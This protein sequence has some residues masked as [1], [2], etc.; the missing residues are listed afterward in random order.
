MEAAI[1][2]DGDVSRRSP[3]RGGPTGRNGSCPQPTTADV[4]PAGY[5][6]VPLLPV[7]YLPRISVSTSLLLERM[8]Q[9]SSILRNK[10]FSSQVLTGD[11]GL[12]EDATTQERF[13]TF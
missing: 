6:P 12:F 10:R 9:K 11:T 2:R 4:P 1:R 7:L 5:P 3:R 13:H 8:S